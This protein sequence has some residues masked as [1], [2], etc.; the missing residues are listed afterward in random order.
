V[1]SDHIG[2]GQGVVNTK[3]LR[4]EIKSLV[5]MLKGES[6][7]LFKTTSSID[8]NRNALAI[9]LAFCEGL[10][11]LEI[12]DGP[13]RKLIVYRQYEESVVILD[14]YVSAHGR[15][16]LEG[17]LLE[18]RFTSLHRL[19]D[20]HVANSYQVFRDFNVKLERSLQVRFVK[21]GE[22]STSCASFE[23]GAEHVM[24][25]AVSWG[26]SCRCLGG[27]VLGSIEAFHSI[28]HCA[29]EFDSQHSL[30]SGQLFGEVD[31]CSLILLIVRNIF[32]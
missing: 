9:I 11:I 14:A 1:D 4:E 8:A 32:Q 28:V 25:S 30:T 6:T 26:P 12:A 15:C 27:L 20:W 2:F 5:G 24:V 3:G 29:L 18:T 22:C 16:L 23:L 31:G 17:D 10:D 7:L 21:A 13:C 19:L